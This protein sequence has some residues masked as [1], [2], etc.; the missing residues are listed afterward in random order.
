MG[1]NCIFQ[2]N[3]GVWVLKMFLL[4]ND[5]ICLGIFKSV[6]FFQDNIGVGVLKTFI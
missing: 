1:Q 5:S 4:K 2:D 6:Q 3:I